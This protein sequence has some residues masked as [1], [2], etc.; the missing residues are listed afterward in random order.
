[1]DDKSNNPA[2]ISAAGL[3][4][5]NGSSRSSWTIS[6]EPLSLIYTY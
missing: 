2:I 6:V 5:L 1:M 3:Y 4:F